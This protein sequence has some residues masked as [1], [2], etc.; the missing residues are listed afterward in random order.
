MK[1]SIVFDNSGDAIPFIALNPE[2]VTY[3]V[4]QLAQSNLNNFWTTNPD[5]AVNVNA[6][7]SELH[8]SLIESNVWMTELFDLSFNTFDDMSYLDQTNLNYLHAAWVNVQSCRYNID[9]KRKESKFTGLPEQ[10]HDMYSDE[11]RFPAFGDVVN[12]I[13]KSRTFDRLNTPLIHGIEESF[14]RISFKC[15]DNWVEFNNPFPKNIINNDSCNLFLPFNHLGRTQYNKFVNFD[16]DLL[17]ADENTFNELLGFVGLSLAPPQTIGYSNEYINWCKQHNRE[18]SGQNIP[19]GNI[20]DLLT[21]LTKYRIIV[22]RNTSAGNNF[23]IELHK[24]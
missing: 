9:Q 22:L 14:V 2:V 6:K 16:L 13:G 4:D 7:I 18:P 5:Y 15:S 10:L 17:H 1:F 12:K 8:Q 23:R 3:Y 19:L 21:N 20:P 11:E 24:G